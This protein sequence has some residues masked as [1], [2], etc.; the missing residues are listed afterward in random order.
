MDELQLQTE[1][2]ELL[3]GFGDTL[4]QVSDRIA[5]SDA[6]FGKIE[7][8]LLTLKQRAWRPPLPAPGGGASQSLPLLTGDTAF[9]NWL[10]GTR[11]AKSHFAGSYTGFR[12]ETKAS[13]L[14]NTGGTVQ[15]GSVRR[16]CASIDAP[17]RT[18]SRRDDESGRGGGVREGNG[19]HT[20]RRLG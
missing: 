11:T 5:K 1:D 12:I 2:R 18:D 6:R 16:T 19:V 17:R 10:Q 9:R 8:D 7:N 3:V 20:R 4:N 13:P 15:V 14:L